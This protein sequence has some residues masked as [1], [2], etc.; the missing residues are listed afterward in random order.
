MQCDPTQSGVTV[1]TPKLII[2]LEQHVPKW[3]NILIMQQFVNFL[4]NHNFFI[5]KSYFSSVYSYI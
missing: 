3:F 5:Y 4:T 2:F 1:I